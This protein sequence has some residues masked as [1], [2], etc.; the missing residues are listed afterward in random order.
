MQNA[1]KKRS[2][3]HLSETDEFISNNNENIL[4]DPVA[5]STAYKKMKSLCLNIRN[6]ILTDIEIHKQ[7]LLPRYDYILNLSSIKSYKQFMALNYL[8]SLIVCG[9]LCSFIDLPNLSSSIYSTELYSRLREF[10]VSCPP[11]GPSPPVVELVIATADFQR[12]LSLW[13]IR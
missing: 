7:D 5:L 13:N 3:R 11:A 9:F 4:M 1:T 10:L 12:D 8:L 2:R 6:E